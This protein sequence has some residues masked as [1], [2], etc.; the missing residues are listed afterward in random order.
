MD[1][2]C[3]I[4]RS[5]QQQDD[6]ITQLSTAQHE[7]RDL[8]RSRFALLTAED[9]DMNLRIAGFAVMVLAWSSAHAAPQYVAGAFGPN[10]FEIVQGSTPQNITRV[11]SSP[12]LSMS[13]TGAA[14]DGALRASSG[15]TA[16]AP[17]GGT[18]NTFASARM[19]GDFFISGPATPTV[20]GSINLHIDGEFH[21]D[22]SPNSESNSILI[23]GSGFGGTSRYSVT[24][25]RFGNV[26]SSTIGGTWFGDHASTNSSSTGLTYAWD[27]T[28]TTP[29]LTLPVGRVF[30]LSWLAQTSSEY[31]QSPPDANGNKF[32]GATGADFGHTITFVSGGDV[33]NL[34]DGYTVNSVDFGIIDN[35]FNGSNCRDGGGG[36]V[37]TPGSASLAL[38]CLALVVLA[39]PRRAIRRQRQAS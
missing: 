34:P 27:D 11:R 30:R 31:I 21:F 13:T 3:Y 33:F 4:D 2:Q 23:Q 20:S 17:G 36:T 24:V 12:G 8:D 9:I 19:E 5:R 16:Q 7:A 26:F 14:G 35:C 22:G 10:G 25:D 1:A 39:G 6:D 18:G 15:V 32:L 28:Y 29:V 38:A 37:P